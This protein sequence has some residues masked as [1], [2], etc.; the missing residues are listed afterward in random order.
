VYAPG[1]I[2]SHTDICLFEGFTVQQGMNYHTGH[3]NTSVL[4]MSTANNSPYDDEIR[5]SGKVIIYEGHDT[6]KDLVDGSAKNYDQPLHLPSGRLTANG[7]FFES[8]NSGIREIVRVYEKIKPGIWTYNGA[9]TLE[10]AWL[11]DVGMRKVVK[12]KL[13]IVPEQGSVGSVEHSARKELHQTRM[14]PSKVK[15][16]VFSRDKGEC[17][18]CGSTNNLHYDHDLPFSKGGT[19]LLAENIRLL[20]AKHNLQKGNKIE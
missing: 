2:I 11:E 4:L 19:S 15:F 13:A 1:D 8:A 7:K 3:D 20:C 14:I 17:V 12:L 6:R 16:Q 10:K 5:D 9:F 18:I